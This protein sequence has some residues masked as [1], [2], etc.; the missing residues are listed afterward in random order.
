MVNVLFVC[1]LV[2]CLF[3]QFLGETK[4]TDL[5]VPVGI[6]CCSLEPADWANLDGVRP[7]ILSRLEPKLL[8]VKS[9]AKSAETS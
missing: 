4:Q 5:E 9:L 2:F 8:P 1:F 3:H 7:R 6:L